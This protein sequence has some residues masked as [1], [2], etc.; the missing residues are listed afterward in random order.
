MDF[1]VLRVNEQHNQVEGEVTKPYHVEKVKEIP[2]EKVVEKEVVIHRYVE[3]PVYN[4]K[5]VEIPVEVIVEKKVEVPVNKYV[6]VPRER[7]VD[8]E[9]DLESVVQVPRYMDKFK[10]VPY[11]ANYLKRFQNPHQKEELERIS[12]HVG[13]LRIENM[14]LKKNLE[15]ARHRSG[16]S[17][18]SRL[19]SI[20][21]DNQNLI[22]QLNQLQPRLNQLINTRDQ[23]RE[24]INRQTEFEVIQEHNTSSQ[25]QLEGHIK[26]IE[27][28][29]PKIHQ[30]MSQDELAVWQ[31]GDHHPSH[32]AYSTGGGYKAHGQKSAH[33]SLH[34][35]V[36]GGSHSGV[37]HNIGNIGKALLS[38]TKVH[39]SHS[40]GMSGHVS[41]RP[42]SGYVTSNN[43]VQSVVTGGGGGLEKHV[44]SGKSSYGATSNSGVRKSYGSQT[45]VNNPEARKSYSSH[46]VKSPPKYH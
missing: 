28:E 27:S 3:V 11:Q 6:E 30:L 8:V 15:V 14:Q 45:V 23:L 39:T 46:V 4:E 37:H 43:I 24:N 35:G 38:P 44:K 32:N 5:V 33:T 18:A 16:H 34:G 21:H 20:Q 22:Q 36:H 17:N 25:V 1:H 7:Y 10:E 31:H 26:T 2:L 19:E 40:K 42:Q 13:Q 9:V 41:P 12:E 29:H